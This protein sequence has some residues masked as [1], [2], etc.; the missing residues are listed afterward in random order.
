MSYSYFFQK[1]G[2]SILP[3]K[4]I[5]EI[6]SH[7]N[8]HIFESLFVFCLSQDTLNSSSMDSACR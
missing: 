1:L 4:G 3:K 2:R 8:K 7:D 6:L 5:S